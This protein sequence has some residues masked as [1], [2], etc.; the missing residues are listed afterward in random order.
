MGGGG[1]GGGPGCRGLMGIQPGRRL[2][3][4][5]PRGKTDGVAM[6]LTLPNK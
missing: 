5:L 3:C 4:G 1:G 2:Y 6:P